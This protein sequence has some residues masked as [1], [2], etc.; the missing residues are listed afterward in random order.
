VPVILRE[1]AESL[2]AVFRYVVVVIASRFVGVAIQELTLFLLLS[3]LSVILRERAES[4]CAV[5]H[6]VVAVVFS[7]GVIVQTA[8]QFLDCHGATKS[9]SQ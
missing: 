9:P 7:F 4:L 6:F 3:W 1:C 8:Y 2:C 5:Y